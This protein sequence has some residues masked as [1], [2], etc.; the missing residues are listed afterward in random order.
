MTDTIHDRTKAA[1]MTGN[2]ALQNSA[3]APSEKATGNEAG[4]GNEGPG[5]HGLCRRP[6]GVA[7]GVDT[8]PPFFELN[9]HHFDGDDGIVDE[10]SQGDDEAPKETL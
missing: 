7:G 8:A 2:R 4:A 10:E 3:A 5:Q 1:V 6:K 9:G